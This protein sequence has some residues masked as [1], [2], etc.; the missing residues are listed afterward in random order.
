MLFCSILDYCA[1]EDCTSFYPMV[2]L[3][4]RQLMHFVR[5]MCTF[6]PYFGRKWW[7]R[8]S[9]IQLNVCDD[10]DDDDEVEEV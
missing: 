9:L 5:S 3:P 1:I 6:F 2:D 10:K 4:V 7:V 8:F